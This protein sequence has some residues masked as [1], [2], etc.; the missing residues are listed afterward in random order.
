MGLLD[1]HVALVTGGAAG[2]GRGIVDR[3]VTEGA[4]VGVLDR[5]ESRLTELAN[6]HP[7]SVVTFAGTVASMADNQ[8]AVDGTVSA[9]GHLDTFIGNAALFD[10]FVRLADLESERI[11]AAFDEIFGV[12]VKGLLFGARAAI[13]PLLETRGSIIFTASVASSLPSGGGPFYTASKHA[14]VGLVKQ[15][16]Y[17]L[18][19][20]VRV[21]AVAPGVAATNMSGLAALGQGVLQSLDPG[22][23]KAM[24][25]QSVPEP[26]DYAGSYLFLAKRELSP[27][28][29][30]TVVTADSGMAVRG[31]KQAAGG[32]D[33]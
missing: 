18:A 33:L 1:G 5:N 12:N 2:I 26:A 13:G 28:M 20:K 31:L 4:R 30:G 14:V 21:N 16:A 3:F 7:G 10:G 24:P 23:P 6:A 11:E 9:F 15:L 27:M 29:T 17:E 19:P 32:F 25:L 22:T 8:G